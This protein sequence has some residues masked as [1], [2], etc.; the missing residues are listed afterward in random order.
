MEIEIR[1]WDKVNEEMI[2]PENI[3]WI[4][5]DLIL[6]CDDMGL[7]DDSPCQRK[8]FILMLYTNKKDKNE[9]KVFVSDIIKQRQWINEVIFK[10]GM[11]GVERPVGYPTG[12]T[13]TEMGF[14]PIWQLDD[15]EKIGNKFENPELLKGVVK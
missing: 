5:S 8:D 14:F 3:F 9:N 2:K 7:Q 6:L 4:G 11:F 13:A 10:G 15:I 1:A 12:S